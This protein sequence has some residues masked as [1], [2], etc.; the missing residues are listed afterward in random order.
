MKA[1]TSFISVI[2]IFIL[3]L[4]FGQAVYGQE[5]SYIVKNDVSLMKLSSK[6]VDGKVTLIGNTDKE[7]IKILMRKDNVDKWFDV[8]LDNGKFHEDIWLTEGKGSYTFYILI[9][10]KDR[11]YNFGPEIKVENIKT[12]DK[13]LVP[14]KDVESDSE[15]IIM[16]ANEITKN[17]E[18]DIDKAKA[19]Y[20]WVS[21]NIFYDFNKFDNHLNNNYDNEYGALNTLELKK[22]VCYD[23][24]A[25]TAALGRASGLQVKMVKGEG[26]T[27]SFQGLHAWNEFYSSDDDKWINVD[28]TFAATA[29]KNYFNNSDFDKEHIKQAEY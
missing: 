5:N 16:L 11:Q 20:D 12:V 29:K 28:T 14:T 4:S 7:K 10:I 18:S 22:G 2:L 15:D 6:N 1:K 3:F 23:Y 8:D 19:I 25:L 24:A 21:N 17:I 13:F 9:H 26:I 27:E